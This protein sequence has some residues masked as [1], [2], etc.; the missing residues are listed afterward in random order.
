ML[1]SSPILHRHVGISPSGHF[2]LSPRICTHGPSR[3]Q[4]LQTQCRLS[5]A[6]PGII[7]TDLPTRRSVRPLMVEEIHIDW[8]KAF[9]FLFPDGN[10]LHA[11]WLTYAIIALV[12]A[13]IIELGT[14]LL[15]LLVRGGELISPQR[16][17]GLVRK[18]KLETM[19]AEGQARKEERA[20]QEALRE[21]V[22]Q[23]RAQRRQQGR[24]G[25]QRQGKDE[26]EQELTD[27]RYI[28]QDYIAAER[29]RGLAWLL[30]YTALAIWIT[31]ILNK[32]SALAP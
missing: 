23:I 22:Q 8:G 25:L 11:S 7:D 24:Q 21:R 19:R 17:R 2:Y 1:H 15:Y 29:L 30:T 12:L 9:S 18:E 3:L 5:D 31:G 20:R 32:D 6:F 28:F 27:K 26:L 14:Q 13:F 16:L 10:V 4:R